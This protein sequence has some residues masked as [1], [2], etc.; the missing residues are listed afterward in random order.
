[1]PDRQMPEW[2]V[3]VVQNAKKWDSYPAT[4]FLEVFCL[5]MK[6]NTKKVG[7]SYHLGVT[8]VQIF[9]YTGVK[10]QACNV[11]WPVL[12][13]MLITKIPSLSFMEGTLDSEPV[14]KFTHGLIGKIVNKCEW[15]RDALLTL[16]C[17]NIN[18]ISR[19]NDLLSF[20]QGGVRD[21]WAK[22]WKQ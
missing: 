5:V 1:M 22:M 11:D 19:V 14:Q 10:R 12:K 15:L 4:S 18:W 17:V 7:K 8:I 6:E 20:R 21:F 16:I 13:S 3:R 2:S 9:L